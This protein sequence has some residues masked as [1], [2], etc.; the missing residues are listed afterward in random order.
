MYTVSKTT[1]RLTF[2]DKYEFLQQIF[3]SDLKLSQKRSRY[4]DDIFLNLIRLH[5]LDSRE[6][7]EHA[8]FNKICN[9]RFDELFIELYYNQRDV[10]KI[11]QICNEI[12]NEIKTTM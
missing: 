8:I 11:E 4:A 5:L 2:N 3:T 12:C 6:A 10:Q 9:S 7:I 1:M